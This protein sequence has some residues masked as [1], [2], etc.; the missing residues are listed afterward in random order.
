V[1]LFG[2]EQFV[3]GEVTL[4]PTEQFASLGRGAFSDVNVAAPLQVTDAELAERPREQDLGGR[5]AVPPP[6]SLLDCC[7][8]GQHRDPPQQGKSN[9]E[10]V[11]A[12]AFDFIEDDALDRT[13]SRKPLVV[14]GMGSHQVG[15]AKT[16]WSAARSLSGQH[17]PRRHC[18][19]SEG[20][21]ASPLWRWDVPGNAGGVKP[22]DR[23]PTQMMRR[24]LQR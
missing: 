18:G 24:E 14:A 23:P 10:G 5:R 12:G 15:K 8:D 21:W 4:D 22:R 20:T 19:H 1:S 9:A 6:V 17:R 7:R 13:L 3:F 11:A 16:S 2:R